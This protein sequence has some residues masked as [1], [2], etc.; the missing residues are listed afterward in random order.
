MFPRRYSPKIPPAPQNLSEESKDWWEKLLAQYALDDPGIMIL[1][2]ALEALD[3]MREA[4]ALLREDGLVVR[5]RFGQS[6]PH[7]AAGIERDAKGIFLRNMKALGLDLEPVNP[8]PGR[9]VGR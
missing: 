2:N 7:P 6:R 1:A 3:R 8:R 4:Q 5:D 9:P